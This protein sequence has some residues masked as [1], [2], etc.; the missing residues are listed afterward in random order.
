[1][2]R[3]ERRVK[4]I[5][6]FVMTDDD[7]IKEI[8]ELNSILEDE[9]LSVRIIN[10]RKISKMARGVYNIIV[11]PRSKTEWEIKANLL[12]KKRMKAFNSEGKFSVPLNKP[13]HVYWTEPF[14]QYLN[15][16]PYFLEWRDRVKQLCEDSDYM[17]VRRGNLLIVS[18]RKPHWLRESIKTYEGFFDK[19]KSKP[20]E[21]KP[22]AEKFLSLLKIPV[23]DLRYTLCD[24][25]DNMRLE[26]DP[27]YRVSSG[28]RP[29]DKEEELYFEYF[30]KSDIKTIYLGIKDGKFQMFREGSMDVEKTA[31]EIEFS[32]GVF[33]RNAFTFI[34]EFRSHD[35]YTKNKK[36]SVKNILDRIDGIIKDPEKIKIIEETGDRIKDLIEFNSFSFHIMD[37]AVHPIPTI[38]MEFKL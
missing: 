29:I 18:E 28:N 13:D 38:R 19:F 27:H 4:R 32:E 36:F 1:M 14:N 35:I 31:K 7:L 20:K 12:Y 34:I 11:E 22:Y 8:E 17:C 33:E 23:W 5:F 2:K 15:K 10:D 30:I 21:Q 25:S 3:S 16:L 6:E 24:I 37:S 9:G 26:L